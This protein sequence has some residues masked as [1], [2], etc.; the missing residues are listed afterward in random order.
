MCPRRNRLSR[1]ASWLPPVTHELYDDVLADSENCAQDSQYPT[2][3][4]GRTNDRHR[5][6]DSSNED[7]DSI[8]QFQKKTPPTTWCLVDVRT[9][10]SRKAG[11]TPF[12]LKPILF[13][14]LL[15]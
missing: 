3:S 4:E 12:L 1:V 14:L 15:G 2:L 10:P 6:C 5:R 8:W 11:I 7:N 9:E 13:W